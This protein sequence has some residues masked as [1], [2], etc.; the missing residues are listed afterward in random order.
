MGREK[1]G[2]QA[3]RLRDVAMPSLSLLQAVCDQ[4]VLPVAKTS[5]ECLR[6]ANIAAGVMAGAEPTP[7]VRDAL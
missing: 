3:D 7:P 5:L 2:R 6:H 4:I 1:E